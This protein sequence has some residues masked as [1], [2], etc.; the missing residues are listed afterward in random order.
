LVADY[1]RSLNV[2][3]DL[4]KALFILCWLHHV[5]VREY[6]AERYLY[7]KTYWTET[8][9]AAAIAAAASVAPQKAL[10]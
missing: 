8:L 1:C 9:E 3:E 7:L 6:R 2:P 5:G 10:A 4:Q